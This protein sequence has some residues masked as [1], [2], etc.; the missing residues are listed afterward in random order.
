VIAAANLEEKR[1]LIGCYYR[2]HQIVDTYC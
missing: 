2:E 1:E